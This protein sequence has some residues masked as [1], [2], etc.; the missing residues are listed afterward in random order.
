M[1]V[2]E[3]LRNDHQD[4]LDLFVQLEQ[5]GSANDRHSLL[6]TI[7]DALEVHA[8]AEEEIFYPALREVSR[9]VDD[10]EAGHDHVRA[11]LA[12]VQGRDV[13][14]REFTIQARV[15]KEAVLNHVA[16]EEGV[17]FMEAGRLGHDTLDRLGAQIEERK[18]ALR[19]AEARRG[20]RAGK[21]AARRVA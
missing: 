4:V 6:D 18:Q 3:L 16:E 12:D 9:R 8:Q 14:S 10:A 7:A 2:T 5:A 21:A 11:L 17:M 19:T 15:L 13:D 1:R 20:A